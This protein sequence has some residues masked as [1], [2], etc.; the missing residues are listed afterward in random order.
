MVCSLFVGF[1][2]LEEYLEIL[3]WRLITSPLLQ[4]FGDL[5]GPS[6]QLQQSQLFSNIATTLTI[7]RLEAGAEST[8][9][10]GRFAGAGGAQERLW[11]L[12][13]LF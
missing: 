5:L 4:A 11:L 3:L 9:S 12:S 13:T 2:S 10:R 8:P 7:K 1:S 6:K